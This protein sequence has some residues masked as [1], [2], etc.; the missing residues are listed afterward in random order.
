[1]N[2]NV[3]IIQPQGY[4]HS[5]GF[6]ELA[7]LV[8]FGLEDLGHTACLSTNRL[9]QDATNILIG[10]H[11]LDP[12]SINQFPKSSIV[13]NTEQVGDA[14]SLW[15]KN[16]VKWIAE[17]TTWDYSE[18]NIAR[19]KTL[20]IDNVKRLR[21]GYHD[22]LRRIP[23]AQVQDID[24]LFY[25]STNERRNKVLDDI[26]NLG[27]NLKTVFGV[28]GKERDELISRSK[29]VLNLHFYN[30]KI[31]EIV[32]VF[33]LMTNGKAVVAEV[34]QETAIDGAYVSGISKAVYD[35]LA[36]SCLRLLGND[37][38]RQ[39]FEERALAT[40]REQAQHKLMASLM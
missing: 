7:E 40:I 34:D 6:L 14:D 24:V 25:G 27:I 29:L 4:V 16:F 38:E 3:C 5:L 18:R 26:R 2:F 21:I 12:S 28:Y 35:D 32:R 11:L 31:F 8:A 37:A 13:L 1:L 15:D 20:G 36:A 9:Q 10:V 22:K 39:A 30:S 19:L 33:Y 17:F 23:K